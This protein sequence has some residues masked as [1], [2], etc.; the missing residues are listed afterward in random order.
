MHKRL[1]NGKYYTQINEPKDYYD[2]YHC[3]EGEALIIEII[4]D[5]NKE[6]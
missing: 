2:Y 4:V 3:L 5:Y 6:T 1:N